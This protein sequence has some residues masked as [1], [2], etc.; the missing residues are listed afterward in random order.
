[1]KDIHR[2]VN[3]LLTLLRDDSFEISLEKNDIVVDLVLIALS[4][5]SLRD[6]LR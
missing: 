2:E 4:M 1:M 6:L 5:C 3:L